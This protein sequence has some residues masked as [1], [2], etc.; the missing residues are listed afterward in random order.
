M[1]ECRRQVFKTGID[2]E[3]LSVKLY[4][5]VQRPNTV[6]W[7]FSTRLKT[8]CS[9]ILL[10]VTSQVCSL[11]MCVS[12]GTHINNSLEKRHAVYLGLLSV[13]DKTI[14][15]LDVQ[16]SRP[17]FHYWLHHNLYSEDSLIKACPCCSKIADVKSGIY[18]PRVVVSVEGAWHGAFPLFMHVGYRVICV[19]ALLDIGRFIYCSVSMRLDH[20]VP[21]FSH[22]AVRWDLGLL[23]T[24]YRSLFCIWSLCYLQKTLPKN[25]KPC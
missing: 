1:T 25:G 6:S 7:L 21:I 18:L 24:G 11:S 5:Q 22:R 16:L 13:T 3:F 19:Q 20:E 4:D 8:R 12:H 2:S 10:V 17:S 15:C 14:A 23:P 9:Y